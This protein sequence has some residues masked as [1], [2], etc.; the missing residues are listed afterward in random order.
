MT[1]HGTRLVRV[2]EKSVA[3]TGAQAES[4]LCTRRHNRIRMNLISLGQLLRQRAERRLRRE[5]QRL[6]QLPLL[7]AP[8]AWQ[9]ALVVRLAVTAVAAAVITRLPPRRSSGPCVWPEGEPAT[10]GVGSS[11]RRFAAFGGSFGGHLIAFNGLSCG[12]TPGGGTIAIL[13]LF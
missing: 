6:L 11:A 12:F 9:H 4:E 8:R 5:L 13:I 10:F 1:R 7:R 3:A 2:H